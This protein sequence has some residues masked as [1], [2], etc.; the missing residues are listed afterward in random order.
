MIFALSLV[1]KIALCQ[2]LSADE[3]SEWLVRSNG[4]KNEMNILERQVEINQQNA[5]SVLPIIN[6]TADEIQNQLKNLEKEILFFRI[7]AFVFMFISFI[8]LVLVLMLIYRNRSHL[9]SKELRN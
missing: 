6:N 5:R 8:L 2:T 4:I 7:C 3:E 1:G 9:F